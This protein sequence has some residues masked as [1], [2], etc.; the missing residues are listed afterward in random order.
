[1]KRNRTKQTEPL[2]AR[3][4]KFAAEWRA[5]A[6]KLPVGKERDELLAKAEQA[7]STAALRAWMTSPELQ[8][9]K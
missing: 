5:A 7:E 9:P 1:M 6:L 4:Q 3:L 8:P 2:E